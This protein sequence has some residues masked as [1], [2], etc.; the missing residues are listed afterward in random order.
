M[1]AFCGCGLKA[2]KIFSSLDADDCGGHGCFC[3]QFKRAS[4][5]KISAPVR[6]RLCPIQIKEYN[7]HGTI[8]MG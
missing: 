8:H 5:S 4:Y 2:A 7:H 6:A 1:R 3:C